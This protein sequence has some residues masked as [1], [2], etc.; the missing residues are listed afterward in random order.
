[1]IRRPP[2]STLFPYTTLFRS[3]VEKQGKDFKENE[4]SQEAPIR[5]NLERAKI[6]HEQMESFRNSLFKENSGGMLGMG[7]NRMWANEIIKDIQ[8]KHFLYLRDAFS[9]EN[10]R[11]YLNKMNQ[12]YNHVFDTENI[13]NLKE[14]AK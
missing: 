8:S 9:K 11:Q 12:K 4:M 13:L 5:D 6:I 10:Y 7:V 1:M 2:R 14:E 3:N